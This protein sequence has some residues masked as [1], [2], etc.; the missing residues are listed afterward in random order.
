MTLRT[1]DLA[2]AMD[3]ACGR[4]RVHDR[5]HRQYLACVARAIWLQTMKVGI[6]YRM[7]VNGLIG[8]KTGCFM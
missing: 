2:A 7:I 5:R 6:A 4:D 1:A 3:E 8:L